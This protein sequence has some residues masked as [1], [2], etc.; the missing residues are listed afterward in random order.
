V[1]L[2]L[3]NLPFLVLL[4]EILDDGCILFTLTDRLNPVSYSHFSFHIYRSWLPWQKIII[5][6]T[7]LILN[8]MHTYLTKKKKIVH[9]FFL[10]ASGVSVLRYL[11]KNGLL[12]I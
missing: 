3:S 12:K 8:I 1:L 10:S 11:E 2:Y 4:Y 6:I 5:I 7:I 9:H